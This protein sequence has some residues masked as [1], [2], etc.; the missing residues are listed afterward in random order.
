MAEIDTTAKTE[1]VKI[2]PVGEP[3]KNLGKNKDGFVSGQEVS[4]SDYFKHLAEQR[5]K[6]KK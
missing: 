5:Q 2:S 3:K 1:E 6:Q 4:Q